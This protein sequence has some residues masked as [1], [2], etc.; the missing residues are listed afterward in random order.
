MRNPINKSW[1]IFDC[2][3]NIL[4]GLVYSCMKVGRAIEL[5]GVCLLLVSTLLS[6]GNKMQ[7]INLSDLDKVQ[8]ISLFEPR[9]IAK[10]FI[11]PSDIISF[12]TLIFI[13]DRYSEDM[14]QV[15]SIDGQYIR[16]LLKSGRGPGE[17]TN[18]LKLFNG[19]GNNIK[20]KSQSYS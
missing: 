8:T 17:S 2:R 14:I 7:P 18:L 20:D 12:D 1:R 4:Y 6:C 5:A 16:G 13:S 3:N 15:Y 10:G 11:N 19:F 9:I